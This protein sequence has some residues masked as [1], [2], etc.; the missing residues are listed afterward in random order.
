LPCLALFGCEDGPNQTFQP[1]PDGAN[2]RWNDGQTPPSTDPGKQGFTDQSGGANKAEICPGD[3]KAKVWAQM[4]KQP[5]VPPIKAAGLDISGVNWQGL[6]IDAAEQTLCQSTNLG[7]AFGDGDQVDYWGD[8]GEVWVDYLVSNRKIQF[9]S[10]WPGYLGTVDATSR[11]GKHKFTIP[12]YSQVQKDGAAYTIDWNNPAKFSVEVNEIY[13]ACTATFAP[14]LP[15][16]PDCT[17]SGACISGAFGDVAYFGFAPLGIFFWVDNKNAA[18]PTP[19]IFTR[20]DMF[21]TKTM[22]FSQAP[23][24]FKLDQEGPLAYAGKLGKAS[25]ACTLKLGVSYGDF[26]KDCVQ[27]ADDAANTTELNKLLGGISHSTERFSFDVSGVDLNFSDKNLK[28]D[29]IIHDKDVPDPTDIATQFTSDQST[30]GPIANDWKNNDPGTGVQDLHGAGLVYLEYVRLVQDRLEYLL[31]PPVKRKLGDPECLAPKVDP[32]NPVWPQGCTGF[33]GFV[34]AAPKTGD[35]LMDAVAI[36]TDAAVLNPAMAL[37]LKPGHPQATFCLDANGDFNTGYYQCSPPAGAYG[38]IFSTSYARLLQVVGQGEVKN[39]PIEARDVRFFWRY[40][41]TAL[42]KYFKVAGTKDETPDGVH[43][44]S[45]DANNLFFD[46]IG[47][48]QFEIGE[49]VDRRFASKTQDPMD[50]VFVADVKNGI[51]NS[52]EFSRETYRGETA[53]YS[54]VLEDQKDG[55]GQEDTGMLTNIFGSPLIAAG[56]HD[57]PQHSAYWCATHMAPNECDNQVPPLDDYGNMELDD[58]G[59]PVLAPYPGAFAGKATRF[60]LG[61]TAIKVTQTY[62]NI[63]SAMVHIPL[64]EDPYDHT[65]K[66]LAPLDILIPWVPKQPGVG[67]PVAITGTLDKFI[68]TAQLDFSGTTISA[69]VDYDVAIDPQT[70][71]PDKNGKLQFLAVETTDFLGDV[72]LCQ[73]PQTGHVL[74]ARMYTPVAEILDWLGAHPSQFQQCGIVIRYSPYNNYVDFITS[75]TNG[76]RLGVTQGG[77]FGRVVD[78]T[79][80]VPGQ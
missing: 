68:N 63:Q 54:A 51:F 31:D 64:Q 76:V 19:S 55:V 50:V 80:F 48:G 71:Q 27:V 40:Y 73:D 24:F 72:F 14:G 32:A 36:G 18:Q 29:D 43:A 4:V 65:S 7:D 30:L 17:Q 56:W 9:M 57:T 52:Y 16:D 67:F 47:A 10:L 60:T 3:K 53:L 21:L 35:P 22:P 45:V 46:S 13:D 15:K 5:I 38:D 33:E 8:N 70:G 39:L 2:G 34:T 69:N 26:L 59:D 25:S 1:T 23:P 11:D 37:G 6:T 20:M 62:P 12:I 49:Y 44:Q 75:L 61:P 58:N 74:R 28:D 78:V 42:V 77:G 41:V 66:A 79:L